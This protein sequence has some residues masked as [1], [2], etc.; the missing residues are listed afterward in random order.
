MVTIEQE[1]PFL[2]GFSSILFHPV[3]TT[4]RLSTVPTNSFR[5]TVIFLRA[6]QSNVLFSV[7]TNVF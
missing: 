3:I 1:R 2:I 5:R 7:D 6:K 4:S